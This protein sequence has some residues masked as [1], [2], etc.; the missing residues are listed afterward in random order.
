[1]N[2]MRFTVVQN[3]I[4][5]FTLLYTFLFGRYFI[6]SSNYEF[7]AYTGLVV[8]IMML[9]YGT[10][11]ITHFPTYILMLVSIWGL[12]HMMGGSMMTRDG[13][14]YAWHIFP[15][16]DG[17]GELY[18]LKFD[19]VVHAGLYAVVGL[20]FIHLLR[21]VYGLK[22]SPLVAFI[23]IMAALGVSALNEIVEFIA[24]VVTPENGVGGYYNTLLD[25]I[26]NLAGAA[27]A[28]VWN[29]RSKR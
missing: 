12:L 9:L 8:G 20:M 21:N 7:I 2:T 28:V 13:V 5:I 18:I 15:L 17:G 24:V 1:M 23:A 4:F 25:I 10:L 27:T 26:F 22:N 19:Q 14:L 11:H 3:G 16:I 6:Q 29:Y